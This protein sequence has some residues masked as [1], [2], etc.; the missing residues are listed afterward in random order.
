M[1]RVI[2]PL[3]WM[4][5]YNYDNY[6]ETEWSPQKVWDYAKDNDW[7]F[8]GVGINMVVPYVHL[9]EH[10]SEW[11]V[12]ITHHNFW[13]ARFL[14]KPEKNTLAYLLKALRKIGPVREQKEEL[15]V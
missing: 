8:Y 5:D 3:V 2:N 13:E 9:N 12:R 6:I 14:P 15:Y 10:W 7:V 11:E 4:Y 1:K